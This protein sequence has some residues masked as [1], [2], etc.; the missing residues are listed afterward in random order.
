MLIRP[1]RQPGSRIGGPG[2]R[3]GRGTTGNGRAGLHADYAGRLSG[4]AGLETGYAG[5][6]VDNTRFPSG[7]WRQCVVIAV[8]WTRGSRAR[9]SP[10]HSGEGRGDPRPARV[11]LDTGDA[12]SGDSR[13]V[14]ME[15]ISAPA[16]GGVRADRW[17]R[18]R[19]RRRRASADAQSYEVGEI[20]REIALAERSHRTLTASQRQFA[21]SGQHGRKS[22]RCATITP[23]PPARKPRHGR[24]SD[25]LP[26]RYQ[27][28]TAA[29]HRHRRTSAAR[30]RATARHGNANQRLRTR[31]LHQLVRIDARRRTNSRNPR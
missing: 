22:H 14:R 11:R 28:H 23:A 17:A 30:S 6:P 8:A 4:D 16:R 1:A 21:I 2:V 20:T 7:T 12:R 24:D 27:V 29:M 25:G 15:G 10:V 5:L 9:A 18:C 26:L 13:P 3:T 31:S 19:W